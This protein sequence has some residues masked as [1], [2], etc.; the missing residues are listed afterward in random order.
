MSFISPTLGQLSLYEVVQDI[1]KYLH[2]DPESHY[3]LVIGSDSHERRVNGH[4]I[5]NY[6]TA[7]VVH[8]IGHGGRYYWKNGAKEKV[9]N[10]RQK[11]YKE[12]QLSLETTE[13]LVPHIRKSLNGSRNWELEIHIDVG[14]FGQTRDMIKE[15]VGMVTGNGYTA[16]TKP[17]SFAATTVADKHT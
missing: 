12:T 5:A 13:A 9:F 10:L 6:I 1:A 16:R 3:R 4:K 7:V 2:D 15:V 17:D 8:R 11:I 14:E